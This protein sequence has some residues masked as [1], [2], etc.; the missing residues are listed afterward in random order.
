MGATKGPPGARV[1]VGCEP[2]G[3]MDAGN[4][5]LV[6]WKS[7]KHTEVLSHLHRLGKACGGP[8]KGSSQQRAKKGTWFSRT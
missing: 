7:G 8:C 5:T 6:L 2:P 1:T 4:Q 3:H